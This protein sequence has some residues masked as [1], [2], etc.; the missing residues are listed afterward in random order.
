[1]AVLDA[2]QLAELRRESTARMAVVPFRK[3]VLNDAIQAVED[4]LESN[5][6]SL[7]Q[8]ID[9]ATSPVRIS[10]VNKKRIL[11]AYLRQKAFRERA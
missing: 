2:E 3:P 11:A 5:R 7:S 6:A 9:A 4:W 8:A 1:M 10:A